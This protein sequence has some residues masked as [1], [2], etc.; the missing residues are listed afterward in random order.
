MLGGEVFEAATL[1]PAEKLP[2]KR[3]VIEQML[4]FPDYRTLGA[5][6]NV[7]Q[8]VMKD[9]YGIMSTNDVDKQNEL[10]TNLLNLEPIGLNTLYSN[11]IHKF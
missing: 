8:V 1:F 2:M 5:A 4:N 10:T 9:G 6:R 7:A 3:Q 11:L